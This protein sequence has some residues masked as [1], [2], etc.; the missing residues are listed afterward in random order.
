MRTITITEGI[1]L[2]ASEEVIRQYEEQVAEL[3]WEEDAHKW[4]QEAA[5]AGDWSFY[6]DLYKD[7]Y[8]V[9]PRW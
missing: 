7:L 4:L 9:R 1:T 8:G 6:S 5:A 2:T 3:Q